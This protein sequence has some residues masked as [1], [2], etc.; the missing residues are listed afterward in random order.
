[1]KRLPVKETSKAILI[2]EGSQTD[3]LGLLKPAGNSNPKK[4]ETLEIDLPGGTR[5]AGESKKKALSRE[6]GKELP[7][8]EVDILGWVGPVEHD[9]SRFHHVMDVCIGRVRPPAESP[10]PYDK[11][12]HRGVIK[13]PLDA[14][15][16]SPDVP[17]RYQLAASAAAAIIPSMLAETAK[18]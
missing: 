12:E 18:N 3:I 7:G 15:I 16:T 1:M 11:T 13:L 10:L 14:L 5:E 17:R 9:S 4:S 6:L 8:Y 2:F